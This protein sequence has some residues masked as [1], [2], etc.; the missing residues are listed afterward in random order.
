MSDIVERLR[1]W[2]ISFS[3]GM[4]A[5]NEIEKLRAALEEVKPLVLGANHSKDRYPKA[6]AVLGEKE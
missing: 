4:E 2:G 5:A 3:L 6:R 1:Y